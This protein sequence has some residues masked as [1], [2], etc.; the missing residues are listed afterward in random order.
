MVL[1]CVE[2]FKALQLAVKAL[3]NMTPPHF[4]RLYN[5]DSILVSRQ[6]H[7]VNNG[8]SAMGQ[9]WLGLQRE[10]SCK[11]SSARGQSVEEMNKTEQEPEWK[12]GN[13]ES[14]MPY[15]AHEECF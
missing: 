1:N 8:V 15:K 7:S 6:S 3:N 13:Q 4:S 9:A 10:T 11:V 14:V 12:K 5:I 2:K